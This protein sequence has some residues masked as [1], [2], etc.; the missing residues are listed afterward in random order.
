MLLL[1]CGEVARPAPTDGATAGGGT[2]AASSGGTG[3]GGWTPCSSPDGY[4]ICGGSA[5]T[6]CPHDDPACSTC[7][8]WE[9]GY[10]DVLS[11]CANDAYQ[12]SLEFDELCWKCVDGCICID[13]GEF[14]CA[15]YDIG[16]LIAQQGGAAQLRYADWGLWTGDPLPLPQ[17][18]PT[19]SGVS[20]CGGNCGGCPAG[21]HCTGRSPLHP[22]GVCFPDEL[23]SC[24][25]DKI[26]CDAGK[27]C[28][29]FTV[30]PSAMELSYEN[31]YCL[32]LETCLATAE[33]L[34]GGGECIP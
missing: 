15:P 3:G 25:K 12:T 18:C 1:G 7:L 14:S 5:E 16:V 21:Q 19:L 11:V 29:F 26:F 6:E 24:S 31:G 4:R 30:E 8:H 10:E 27:A 20:V 34:P 23:N 9:I 32:P 2:A 28:F 13:F 33:K 17:T 22:Y